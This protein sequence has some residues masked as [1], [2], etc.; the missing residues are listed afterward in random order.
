MPFV[1]QNITFGSVA[2]GGKS[3]ELRSSCKTTIFAELCVDNSIYFYNYVGNSQ[4]TW[5]LSA[6]EA[7]KTMRAF[8]C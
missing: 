4:V 7:D 8:F 5:D 2:Q 1:C 6:G 3:R